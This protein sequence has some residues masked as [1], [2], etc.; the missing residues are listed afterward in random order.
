MNPAIIAVL[1]AKL[2]QWWMKAL[3]FVITLIGGFIIG[4]WKFA[5]N[6]AK[7]MKRHWLVPIL[8]VGI[9]CTPLWLIMGFTPYTSI[10]HGFAYTAIGIAGLWFGLLVVDNLKDVYKLVSWKLYVLT[11]GKAFKEQAARLKAPIIVQK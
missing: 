1:V 10:M 2:T 7:E 8:W 11:H 9:V 3:I 4:G 5:L 6:D